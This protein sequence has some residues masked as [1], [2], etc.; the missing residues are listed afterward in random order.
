MSPPNE[1]PVLPSRLLP[2]LSLRLLF[3]ITSFAALI[4]SMARFANLGAITAKATLFAMVAL[5]AFFTISAILF[6]LSRLADFGQTN[7]ETNA[8]ESDTDSLPPQIIPPR[9]RTL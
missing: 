7:K 1:E 9:E 2:R 6:C 4:S 8:V 3:T 5:V